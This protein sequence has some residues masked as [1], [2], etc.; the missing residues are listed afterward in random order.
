M[1]DNYQFAFKKPNT[2][3]RKP[4]RRK[5]KQTLSIGGAAENFLS[6]I[7]PLLKQFLKDMP[8]YEER[9]AQAEIRTMQAVSD[10]IGIAK[11]E[12]FNTFK[13]KR[14]KSPKVFD[15]HHKNIIKIIT[16]KRDKGETFEQI[17][18]CF[19]KEGIPTLSKKGKWHA[20]TVH[21]FYVDNI[22]SKQA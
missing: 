22:L 15:E 6:T 9:K 18:T 5:K 10:I 16:K 17:A 1:K 11:S 12:N 4:I 19:D 7:T 13:R 2:K 21:R 14:K 3:R 20:Q 8:E